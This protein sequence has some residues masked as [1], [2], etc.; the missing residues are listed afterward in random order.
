MLALSS[1]FKYCATLP[2]KERGTIR[3]ILTL[4]IIFLSKVL[5][6]VKLNSCHTNYFFE[7]YLV[8]RLSWLLNVEIFV[9]Y[10]IVRLADCSNIISE[11]VETSTNV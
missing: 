5:A 1:I 4:K 11:N 9:K 8:V 10:Y 7:V 2:K 3:C 6:S